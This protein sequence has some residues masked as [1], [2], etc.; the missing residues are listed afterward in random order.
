M[1]FLSAPNYASLCLRNFSYLQF[2]CM[3][4]SLC[5]D[6]QLIKKCFYAAINIAISSSLSKFY[7]SNKVAIINAHQ[8]IIVQPIKSS[9]HVWWKCNN[10]RSNSCAFALVYL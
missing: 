9:R 1:R 7:V 2:A 5:V 4:L 10:K 8:I 6:P 3:F